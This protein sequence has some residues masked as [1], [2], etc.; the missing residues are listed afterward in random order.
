MFYYTKL[1]VFKPVGL[2]L[3][4]IDLNHVVYQASLWLTINNHR[5]RL[6]IGSLLYLFQCYFRSWFY[7]QA[8]RHNRGKPRG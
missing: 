4:S 5:Y 6:S 8:L 7:T 1:V 2:T 3:T